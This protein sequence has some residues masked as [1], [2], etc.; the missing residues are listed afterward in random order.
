LTEHHKAIGCSHCYHTGYAGRKAIYEIIPITSEL[1]HKIKSNVL[2]INQYLKE[3]NIRTLK[4][5]ALDLVVKG[6]TSIDEV[7]ALL[8]D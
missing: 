4:E 5:N 1:T 3:K 2:E 6:E 7:Y 8:I